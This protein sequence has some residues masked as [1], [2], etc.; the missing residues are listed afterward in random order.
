VDGIKAAIEDKK[1]SCKEKQKQDEYERQQREKQVADALGSV[2]LRGVA[3]KEQLLRE[4]NQRQNQTGNVGPFERECA[5]YAD[6]SCENHDALCAYP[7]GCN[8]QLWLEAHEFEDI[9][10]WHGMYTHLPCFR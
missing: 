7:D 5:A 10:G 3:S 4:Q 6:P 8:R 1:E 2:S 9:K